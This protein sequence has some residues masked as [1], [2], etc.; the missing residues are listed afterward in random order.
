MIYLQ[1]GRFM[2]DLS[3]ISQLETCSTTDY[4]EAVYGYFKKTRLYRVDMN[5]S[6]GSCYAEFAAIT[7]HVAIQSSS[8]DVR[9]AVVEA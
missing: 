3:A 2:K 1:I 8:L 5:C 7:G 6:W 9:P 4:E